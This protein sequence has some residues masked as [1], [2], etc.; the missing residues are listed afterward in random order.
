MR[1]MRRAKL[2][3]NRSDEDL[4]IDKEPQPSSSFEI[5]PHSRIN[6]QF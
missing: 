5:A 1:G 3:D 4:S 6:N 2:F